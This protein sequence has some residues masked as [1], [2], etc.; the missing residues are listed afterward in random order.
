MC[1]I[2]RPPGGDTKTMRGGGWARHE[3]FALF[4]L[5]QFVAFDSMEK[6]ESTF[7]GSLVRHCVSN[8]RTIF[9]VYVLAK[10]VWKFPT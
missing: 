2:T 7:L 5:M 3:N 9:I 8:V 6:R 4:F 10:Y 1:L